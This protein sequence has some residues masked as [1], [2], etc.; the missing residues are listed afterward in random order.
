MTQVSSFRHA[1][2]QIVH[3]IGLPENKIKVKHLRF[4]PQARQYVALAVHEL[5]LNFFD[6]W[7]S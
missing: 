5:R 3:V 2:E 6:P 1:R 4:S 7:L